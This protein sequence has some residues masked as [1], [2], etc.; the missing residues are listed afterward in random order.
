M[1]R[2]KNFVAFILTHGRPN[3]VKTY[4][5]LRSCGYTGPIVLVIDDEDTSIGEYKSKFGEENIYIINKR[6]IAKNIDEC[7]NFNDR[8][9]IVYARNACFD[10]AEELGYE[11]FVE[12]DDDYYYFGYHG[13]KGGRITRR[14]DEIFDI[15]VD[16]VRDTPVL[17]VA[18]S[19]GGDHIGG[20]KEHIPMKRKAMN[21]FVCSIHKR[22]KFI[23]RINEDVNTYVKLGSLG[24][25][26]ITIMNLKLDQG[27]TQQSGGGMSDLYVNSG[28]YVK[29]FYTVMTNP[30]CVK[31][32]LMGTNAMRI[33]HNIDWEKAVPKI[34]REEFKKK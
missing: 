7:D 1:M 5:Y 6:E 27:D 8:R 25:I 18:M 32:R 30:S 26:F 15:L 9:A 24:G 11:Y 28:T 22:F 20:F 12:L 17:S 23:G 13:T 3:N 19:Q 33:H 2:N 10:I 4:R 21:S 31:V 29:S 16:F 14:L 34:I